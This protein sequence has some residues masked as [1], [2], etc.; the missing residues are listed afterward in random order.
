MK[1][2]KNTANLGLFGGLLHHA[3]EVGAHSLQL[4]GQLRHFSGFPPLQLLLEEEQVDVD[5][6]V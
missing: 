5:D 3:R 6:A 1:T 2:G 4:L